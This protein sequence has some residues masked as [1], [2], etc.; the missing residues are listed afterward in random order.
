MNHGTD[1]PLSP[2][3]LIVVL[4]MHRSGTSAL[5]RGLQLLG[6]GLGDNLMPPI[7]GNND[8]GFW[9][10]WD[11][12]ALNVKLLHHLGSEWHM[13]GLAGRQQSQEECL[14]EFL[15]PAVD[16]LRSKLKNNTIFG[17]K[18]PRMAR[19][20]P[21]WQ[22][23]FRRLGLPVGYV[24]A[25]RNPL[26]V[27]RSL[28]NRDQFD[29][30]KSYYLWLEHMIP[31]VLH[32][33]NCRRAVVDYDRLMEAPVIQL[34]R[35][36]RQLGLSF[37]ETDPACQE[38]IRQYLANDLRHTVFSLSDLQQDPQMP[39]ELAKAYEIL[40]QLA[41][42]EFSGEAPA[43]LSE[44]QAV[45]KRLTQLTP[46]FLYMNRQERSLAALR[47]DLHR[48]L[49]AKEVQIADLRQET[50]ERERVIEA[51]LRSNSWRLTRALRCVGQWV[52]RLV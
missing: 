24:L 26:S 3:Q 52:R 36:S 4:G 29:P 31:A 28:W 7:A 2:Q 19:L 41:R 13:L 15:M 47:E 50:M 23:A 40:R 1:G 17:M 11:I 43:V 10:D 8:K 45:D 33:Q 39:I 25:V 32:T 37:C 48:D 20:L 49:L 22:A 34:R 51:I 6:V 42:D 14:A 30:V 27:A 21:F 12:N 5:T 46:L 35:I 38:Y 16:L 44:L 18:D 9:E